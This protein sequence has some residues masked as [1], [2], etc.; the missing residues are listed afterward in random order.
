MYSLPLS[1]EK[2]VLL[3]DKTTIGIGGQASFFATPNDKKELLNILQWSKKISKI[4]DIRR[5]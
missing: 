4:V 5:R 3:A 2:N 1:I